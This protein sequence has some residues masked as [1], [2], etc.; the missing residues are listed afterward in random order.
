MP[1]PS[2]FLSPV[3]AAFC[4]FIYFQ[5]S[6]TTTT[7]NTTTTSLF[8]SWI[9]GRRLSRWLIEG[10]Q[11]QSRTVPQQ[12]HKH[13]SLVTSKWSVAQF[14]LPN[15]N[16]LSASE[17][18]TCVSSL[19]TS[20]YVLGSVEVLV[21][22]VAHLRSAENRR[23]MKARWARK[24]NCFGLWLRFLTR[25]KYSNS[26]ERM[27]DGVADVG[28]GFHVHA[29]VVQ[30]LGI[31]RGARLGEQDTEPPP[32]FFRAPSLRWQEHR[33]EWKH[34]N[35][36]EK[37]A[38]FYKYCVFLQSKCIFPTDFESHVLTV[39]QN[40]IFF[41]SRLIIWNPIFF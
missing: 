27:A 7:R 38:L 2:A 40:P 20:S 24:I 14:H 32:E 10:N 36:S 29:V 39:C 11:I 26:Q 35:V 16:R 41:P 8:N 25:S 13:S 1:R 19:E 12:L 31:S 28:D 9:T 5:R 34:Y 22:E 18:L 23:E 17:P 6:Q 21:Q 33:K 30:R 15:V 3:I 4:W 37:I